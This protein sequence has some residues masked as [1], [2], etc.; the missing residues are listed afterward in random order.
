MDTSPL[1]GAFLCL[2][3]AYNGVMQILKS[4]LKGLKRLVPYIKAIGVFF[5]VFTFG[6]VGAGQFYLLKRSGDI[7]DNYSAM[8]QEIKELR[9]KLG[10]SDRK[11]ERER[12]S[13]EIRLMNGIRDKQEAC[14]V[15]ETIAS[16]E[17]SHTYC[18]DES[19]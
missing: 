7:T 6:G 8:S 11:N 1:T 16:R 15:L 3:I 9:F 2:S 14:R 17:Y 10:E 19:R 12:H 5:V 4:L 18:K 13:Q